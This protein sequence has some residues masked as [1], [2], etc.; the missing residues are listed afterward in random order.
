MLKLKSLISVLLTDGQFTATTRRVAR[1]ISQNQTEPVYS[2]FFSHKHTVAALTPYGSY[3]GMELFYV[4]NNWENATLGTGPLF[5]AQDDSVQKAMLAYWTNFAKTGNP[6][7]SG[8]VNWPQ[9]QSAPDCYLEIKATPDGS[10]CGLRTAKSDF[11]DAVSSFL[12]D[13]PP[14]LVLSISE[15]IICFPFTQIQRKGSSNCMF[16]K[17]SK[18]RK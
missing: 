5:K 14:V 1:C 2:Y 6:N 4:F 13:V 11:W 12:R 17:D 8:L 9:Y 7:A 10:A 16:Q 3:H 18:W 15:V